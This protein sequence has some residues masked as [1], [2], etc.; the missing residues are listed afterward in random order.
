M[1][2]DG[3]WFRSLCPLAA[4]LVLAGCGA[5]KPASEPSGEAGAANERRSDETAAEVSESEVAVAPVLEVP[6]EP[7]VAKPRVQDAAPPPP[8]PASKAPLPLDL[9]PTPELVMPKVV[10]SAQHAAMSPIKVG[11]PFP[12]FELPDVGGATRSLAELHGSTLTLVVFWNSVQPTALEE[13]SD[14]N[15]YFL[16]RFAESGL[17]VVAVNVGEPAAQAAE[18]AKAAGA[19]YVILCDP[20]KKAFA[21]VA[22]EKLPR[23]YLL[24]SSGRVIWFDL[25]YSPTTRRDLAVVIRQTLGE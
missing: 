13:L 24:D 20:E 19:T 7:E 23:S 2:R 6:T 8:L 21:Q 4:A 18:L 5:S 12:N 1:R 22:T 17:A 11:D 14:M 25:E 9:I 16:P 10:L 15:R 3:C